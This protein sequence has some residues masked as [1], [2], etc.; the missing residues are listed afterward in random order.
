MGRSITDNLLLFREAKWWAYHHQIP[1]MFLLLDF[2]KAYDRI[3]WRY[4]QAALKAL[5]FSP[6]F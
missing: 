5:G 4:V 2:S 6:K 3:E 1:T